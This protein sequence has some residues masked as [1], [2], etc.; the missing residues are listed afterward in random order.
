MSVVLSEIES[1]KEPLERAAGKVITYGLGLGYY[2]FMASEK[3]DV[4]SVTVVELNPHMISL[5]K[6]KLLPHFPHKEKVHIIEG[7]A[8]VYIKS[9]KTGPSTT[10]SATS[11][12]ARKTASPSIWPL[13]GPAAPSGIPPMI[14]G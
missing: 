11:G 5:F 1:M 4:E 3:E 2:T 8:L 6:K 14:T 10:A 13:Q 7:D 12:Q 9:R